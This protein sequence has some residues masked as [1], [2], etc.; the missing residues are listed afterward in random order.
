MKFHT[1]GQK[2]VGGST[3]L[4]HDLKPQHYLFVPR[5]ET[6]H[7]KVD[8]EVKSESFKKLSFAMLRCSFVGF[9]VRDQYQDASSLFAHV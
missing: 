7:S 8:Q 1:L 6:L 5:L 4:P 9:F 3:H 2:C